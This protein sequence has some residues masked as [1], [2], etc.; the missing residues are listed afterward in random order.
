LL[1][2]DNV[3]IE[4]MADGDY[5]ARNSSPGWRKVTSTLL[6]GQDVGVIARFADRAYAE[7][8]RLGNGVPGLN[9]LSFALAAA[10]RE[11]DRDRWTATIEKMRRDHRHHAHTESI[12]LAGQGL[13]ENH[14][15]RLRNMSH[16]GI[17]TMLSEATARRIALQQLQRCRQ[18]RTTDDGAGIAELQR[19]ERAV[20]DHMDIPG[21]AREALRAEDGRGFTA[22][23]RQSPAIGTEA[24]IGRTLVGPS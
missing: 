18:G 22:P 16:D 1:L 6:G 12:A 2:P 21:L 11:G 5:Y 9:H 20:I 17:A 4:I 10:A 13:L 3:R 19:R 7:T 15:N 14:G 24:L 8:M 23:A